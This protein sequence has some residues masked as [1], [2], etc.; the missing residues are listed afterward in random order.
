MAKVDV[1]IPAFNAAPFLPGAIESVISQTE[2]DWRI[3]LVDDGSTDNT[4]EIVKSFADR[5]GDR[6]L[7]IHQPNKGLP[8][9][10][11][12]AIRNSVSPFLA[13]LDA[14]DRWLPDRLAHSLSSLES[15]PE[16]G[17][18]YGLISRIDE[19]GVIINT[20][21]GNRRHSEGHIARYIYTREVDLPCPT[22]TFR[23]ACVEKVGFFDERMNAT[24][25]RDMWLRIAMQYEVAFVPHVIALYRTSVNSMS[26]D[27]TRMLSA[28]RRFISKHYGEPGCG[29]IARQTALGRAYKQRAEALHG[30]GKQVAALQSAAYSVILAP[31]EP[32]NIRTVASI[33]LEILGSCW[34]SWRDRKK[35]AAR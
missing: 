7:Y 10:R 34:R 9:A 26:G 24:E 13:L 21:A 32:R 12:A 23:R 29:W 30:R 27:L 19:D 31:T 22:I 1:I 33:A 15:R 8:A 35:S 18:S 6:L 2:E 17:L 11:N 25:D 20:F 16:A 4:P 14:D 3:V 5:L 28:Q